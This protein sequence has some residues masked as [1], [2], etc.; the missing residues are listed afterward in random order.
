MSV[1]N[2]IRSDAA[3]VVPS[4]TALERS[5]TGNQDLASKALGLANPDEQSDICCYA[6]MAD[7]FSRDAI[8]KDLLFSGNLAALRLYHNRDAAWESSGEKGSVRLRQ[9]AKCAAPIKRASPNSISIIY[10]SPAPI[11]S[12]PWFNFMM[13]V[14]TIE[15]Y[16][17]DQDGA[18]PPPIRPIT[19]ASAAS[20]G[21]R[22]DFPPETV[23]RPTEADVVRLVAEFMQ[24]PERLRKE[25]ARLAQVADIQG[26]RAQSGARALGLFTVQVLTRMKEA[27]FAAGC[28]S[29]MLK[30]AL[31]RPY[32]VA[33]NA[34]KSGGLTRDR[35]AHLIYIDAIENNRASPPFVEI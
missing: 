11:D 27:L 4:I 32:A 29:T 20:Y 19:P 2:H 31:T 35:M 3:G 9:V 8:T 10:A 13:G 21:E 7:R 14:S 28:G 18:P 17:S 15:F 34:K 26:W 6:N 30:V 33:A 1:P 12:P 25:C 22:P 16:L 5:L 24:M 23:A